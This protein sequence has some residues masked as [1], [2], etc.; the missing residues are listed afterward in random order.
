MQ[1][2]DVIVHNFVL[3]KH[4]VDRENGTYQSFVGI[5]QNAQVYTNV[6]PDTHTKHLPATCVH[7]HDEPHLSMSDFRAFGPIS[8]IGTQA[9]TMPISRSKTLDVF[10]GKCP[11]Y[12]S[13]YWPLHM[14]TTMLPFLLGSSLYK[15][16]WWSWEWCPI[17][18]LPMNS[19]F[20]CA[21]LRWDFLGMH[22]APSSRTDQWLG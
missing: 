18:A 4:W 14:C 1:T 8:N 15:C 12:Y 2:S 3:E 7:S 21:I 20:H 13:I 6:H 17:P 10:Q 19:G 11:I 22:V 16:V 5:I 9:A